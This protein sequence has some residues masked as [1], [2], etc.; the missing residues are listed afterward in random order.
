MFGHDFEE[1]GG[2]KCEGK[3]LAIVEAILVLHG[4]ILH[5]LCWTNPSLGHDL[6][7]LNRQT[8]LQFKSNI[9]VGRKC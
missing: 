8:T 6:T 9:A 7:L 5:A 3:N 2:I 1:K 4:H